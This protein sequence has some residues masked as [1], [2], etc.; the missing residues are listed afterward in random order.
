[1]PFRM[2]LFKCLDKFPAI[3][4]EEVCSFIAVPKVI[5]GMLDVCYDAVLQSP[6]RSNSPTSWW[7]Q[8]RLT[9]PLAIICYP[10]D[11]PVLLLVLYKHCNKIIKGL[12]SSAWETFFPGHELRKISSVPECRERHLPTDR[13][14]KHCNQAKYILHWTQNSYT[15]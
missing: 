4:H 11:I 12:W 15:L 8:K 2:R 14:C 7:V 6:S 13:V 9:Y 10:S 5:G 3:H 1:M